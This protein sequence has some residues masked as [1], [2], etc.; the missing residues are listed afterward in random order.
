M[1]IG[2]VQGKREPFP[3]RCERENNRSLRAASRQRKL[4]GGFEG[5]KADG[6]WP[7]TGNGSDA[8]RLALRGG[9]Y[10]SG[11][12]AGLFGLYLPYGRSPLRPAVGFRPALALRSEARRSRLSGR[13]R[14]K[15]SRFLPGANGKTTGTSARQVGNESG[16]EARVY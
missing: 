3:S 14:A 9:Y 12:G 13:N 1:A 15:G 6:L 16:A 5:E 8:E 7:L 10:G 11:T 4:R 2:T